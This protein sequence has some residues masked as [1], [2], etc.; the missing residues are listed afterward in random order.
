MMEAILLSIFSYADLPQHV[1]ELFVI[2]LFLMT[3]PPSVSLSLCLSVSVSV[4]V[5]LSVCLCQS[6]CLCLSVCLTV[7]VCLSVCLSLSLSLSL[8]SPSP[9]L[10]LSLP[11]L[12]S[13]CVTPP[14]SRLTNFYLSI[15]LNF[16]PNP[17]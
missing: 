15:S 13:L 3:P 10:S 6:V 7:S 2:E 8:P 5:C 11:S 12:P 16:F 17:L 9:R 1:I 14:P 4:S